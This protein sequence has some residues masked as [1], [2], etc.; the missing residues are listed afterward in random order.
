MKVVLHPDVPFP[1]MEQNEFF[2]TPFPKWLVI[3][4]P[5]LQRLLGQKDVNVPE[6]TAQTFHWFFKVVRAI[7]SCMPHCTSTATDHNRPLPSRC[8]SFCAEQTQLP[9]APIPML[10]VLLNLKHVQQILSPAFVPGIH[11]AL[12][13]GAAAA[14]NGGDRDEAGSDSIAYSWAWGRDACIVCF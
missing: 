4:M 2:R 6:T 10:A 13:F 8:A 12:G 3:Q 5:L 1:R 11:S 14:G 7:V 9:R